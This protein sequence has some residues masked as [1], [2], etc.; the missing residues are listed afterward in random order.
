MEKTFKQKNSNNFVWTPLGGR[1]NIYKIFAFKFTLRFLQP[2]IVAIICHRC[3]RKFAAGVI[4]TGG[5]LPLA[6]LTPAANLPPVSL[7]PVANLPPVSLIPAAILP[8]VSLTP[9]A[10][11]P[12]VSL[13]PVVHLVSR[14]SPRIFEKIRNRLNGIL[15]G[16]RE[17]DS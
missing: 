4:D 15:W 13:I 16:G 7:T 12:P 5:N 3:Q 17:T 14:I 2:D 9:V 11:L 1:V 8:P 10:N 6:S